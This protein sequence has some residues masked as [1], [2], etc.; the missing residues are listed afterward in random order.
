MCY[1][2]GQMKTL[3]IR[4]A[5]LRE[6]WNTVMQVITF[7]ILAALGL[8]AMILTGC[9]ATGRYGDPVSRHWR[10]TGIYGVPQSAL[11]PDPVRRSET[12]ISNLDGSYQYS[13]SQGT[14][15]SVY[16]DGGWNQS[17][18]YNTTESYTPPRI[19][20]PSY[21]GGRGIY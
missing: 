19:W 3:K 15:T 16:P 14:Q 12:F 8:V 11:P 4:L 21:Y 7:I 5:P 20:Y 18:Y 17:S 13:H 1:N 9:T 2:I 6:P 10:S